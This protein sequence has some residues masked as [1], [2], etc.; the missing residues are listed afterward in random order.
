M[1]SD[2]WTE[3]KHKH[4][5]CV[6]LLRAVLPERSEH[7]AIE[8]RIGHVGSCWT[9][10]GPTFVGQTIFDTWTYEQLVIYPAHHR[11]LKAARKRMMK[12]L[13]ERTESALS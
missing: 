2:L 10:S 11:A 8:V 6:T 4:F 5:G 9:V 7:E 1:V 12:A 3:E 13:A